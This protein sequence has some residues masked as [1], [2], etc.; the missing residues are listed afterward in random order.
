MPRRRLRTLR[1]LAA[2]VL[3]A[4]APACSDD[5]APR[6]VPAP[7]EDAGSRCPEG[8]ALDAEL[9]ACTEVL[10]PEPCAPGT[11]ALLGQAECQPVGWTG[12]CP[13]GMARDASGWGCVDA[14]PAAGCAGATRESV[15]AGG[16]APV[17]DCAGPFPP[18]AA[19]LFVDDDGPTDATHF[20]TIFDAV[21]AAPVGA[22]IAVEEGR[23]VE[24]VEPSKRVSIVGRCP[25][26]VVVAPPQGNI[27]AGVYVN[28]AEGVSVRGVT[29]T[30][31]PGGVLA[32]GGGLTLEDVVVDQNVTVGVYLRFGAKVTMRR[33]KVS[34]TARGGG[35]VG[36]GMVAYDG[37]QLV[38][39]DVAVV[40]NYF[41]NITVNHA[42]TRLEAT[43]VYVARNTALS[44][45][46]AEGGV[47]VELGSS[48]V[49]SRSV[50]TDSVHGGVRV[51]GAGSSAEIVESIV[52]RAT[53]K[54]RDNAGVGVLALN[55]AKVKIVSS[56]VTEHPVLGAYAGEGASLEIE[57]SVFLGP[58]ASRVV[59]F[60]R[61]ANASEGAS[62]DVRDSAFIDLPQSGLGVQFDS[63]GNFDRVLVQGSRPLMESIGEFGG[64]GLLVE[65]GSSA[66]VTR[67]S[68]ES[69][70]LSGI[71]VNQSATATAEGVL[72]RATRIAAAAGTGSAAQVAREGQLTVRRSAFVGN[73]ST[74]AIAAKTCTLRLV[75]STLHGTVKGLDDSFGHGVT[76]FDD[77]VVEL[78]NVAVFDNPGVGF[79][80]DGGRARVVG[81]VFARNSVGVHAQ[82]GAQLA[83][84][85]DASELGP[86]EVR[87]SS[88]TRFVGNGSRV[89]S[90]VVAVP[91]PLE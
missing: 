47:V 53:G 52:R 13:A 91:R 38:L 8:F 29:I 57:K 42:R 46:A 69:N 74:T 62:L 73:A 41:R 33:S 60:G 48:A 77:A 15:G 50:V 86:S 76:V 9:D 67:S 2:A 12:E 23:Y 18:A 35:A 66:T 65:T 82:N 28:G 51:E 90:G 22:T 78:E 49:L 32:E 85:D 89:G 43:G 20:R 75:D 3:V 25:E 88:S 10:P 45:S 59:E 54:L 70:A 24:I 1:S 27:R 79:V 84:S 30:G 19:T 14:V 16:C 40:D 36:G 81:G 80:S 4:L 83:E 37:S 72:V 64:F 58:P 63:K 61:G 56:A 6:G 7:S 68:F 11:M 17:G 34:R 55:A 5:A 71:S 26:K 87:V 44:A 39:E 31:F 21:A